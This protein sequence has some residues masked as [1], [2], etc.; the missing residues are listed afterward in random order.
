M[1]QL[2]RGHKRA[3]KLVA[4]FEESRKRCQEATHI[5]RANA[6]RRARKQATYDQWQYDKPCG[7]ES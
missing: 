2:N 6:R 4:A 7:E 1:R 5:M 3:E